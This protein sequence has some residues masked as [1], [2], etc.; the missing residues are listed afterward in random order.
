M[1]QA[2]GFEAVMSVPS[3]DRNLLHRFCEPRLLI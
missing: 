3:R 1:R 2:D